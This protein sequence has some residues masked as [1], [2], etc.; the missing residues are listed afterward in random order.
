MKRAE[1]QA[2]MGGAKGKGKT[3]PRGEGTEVTL[4]KTYANEAESL[5]SHDPDTKDTDQ[6]HDPGTTKDNEQSHDL[7]TGQSSSSQDQVDREFSNESDD[8]NPKEGAHT[9]D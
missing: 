3:E 9:Q 6:S 2:L 5:Q 4:P 7:D 1:T 8:T